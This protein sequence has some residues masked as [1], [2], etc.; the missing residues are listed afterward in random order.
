MALLFKVE[1]IVFLLTLLNIF[2]KR[3]VTL[4]NNVIYNSLPLYFVDILK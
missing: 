2:Y 3:A 1:D 4:K